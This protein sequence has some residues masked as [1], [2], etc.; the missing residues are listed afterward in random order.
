[1]EL[2]VNDKIIL[3]GTAHV[4]EKSEEEVKGAI[5]KYKPRVVAVELCEGRYNVLTNKKR[6]EESS[7]L[8]LLKSRNIYLFLAQAFFSTIQRKIGEEKGIEP[9]TEFIKAIEIAKEK[10]IEIAL[11]DRDITITLKRAWLRMSFFEKIKVF[12]ASTKLVFGAEEEKVD[13]EKIMN[14]DALTSLT[15]EVKRYAP[16]VGEV[17]IDERDRYIAKKIIDSTKKGKVL[18]VIGAGHL[19]GVKKNILNNG[20]ISLEE[21]E[22]LPKK[23]IS[24][25]KV[26]GYSIP[27]IFLIAILW[28]LYK[29]NFSLAGKAFLYWFLI[30]GSFASLGAIISRAHPYSI[31][32]AFLVAWFTTL[33]PALAAG[34]FSGIVEAK[35]RKPMIKDLME[36]RK[37]SKIRELMNNKFMRV[38][39]VTA[40]TNVTASI[41]TFIGIT[42]I[43]KLGLGG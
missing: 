24:I 27:I 17:L 35:M 32:T 12:W 38:L 21:L 34:W 23:R 5:E 31:A 9:G 37:I 14:E 10:N 15:N 25:T 39:I 2:V 33:H 29:G 41:G 19:N 3:L 26:I 11:V 30:T 36:I 1:M 7:I 13:I 22:K 16:G 28:L 4:W 8:E 43:I 6:W 20:S 18:A 40:L 42:Y